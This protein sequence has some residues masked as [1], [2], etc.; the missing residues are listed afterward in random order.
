VKD[1]EVLNGGNA[2]GVVVRVGST[3]RKPWTDATP[4]VLAFM[5]AVR[6]AGV[7]VPSI[8]G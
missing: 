5:T 2:S 1:E 3:V 7:D 4:S 8:L 6:E